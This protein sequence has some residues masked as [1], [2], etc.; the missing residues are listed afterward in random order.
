MLFAKT[1]RLIFNQKAEFTDMEPSRTRELE[2]FYS[3]VLSKSRLQWKQEA[4]AGARDGGLK[5]HLVYVADMEG[6]REEVLSKR[7]SPDQG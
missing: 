1:H 2:A 4:T 3:R 7:H 5:P 6:E